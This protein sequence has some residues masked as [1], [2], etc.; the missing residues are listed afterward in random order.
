MR[1]VLRPYA[2]FLQVTSHTAATIIPLTDTASS[3]LPCNYISVDVSGGATDV[4]HVVLSGIDTSGTPVGNYS[5]GADANGVASG[6]P[7]QFVAAQGGATVEF[8]LHDGDRVPAIA[9][10]SVQGAD[11]SVLV[12]Y[13]QVMAANPHRDGYRP[14]G[15]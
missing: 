6:T 15:E 10:R 7:G 1:Q 4:V 2:K 12:Q 3:S 13:G 11:Y 8:S 5:F 14:K 9:T